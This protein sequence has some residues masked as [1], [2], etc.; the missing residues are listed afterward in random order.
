MR[1]DVSKNSFEKLQEW[2]EHNQTRTNRLLGL[3][4]RH[5]VNLSRWVNAFKKPLAH[6]EFLEET[7]SLWG[8]VSVILEEY[9]E[10][11]GDMAT[12]IAE[13]QGVLM[14]FKEELEKHE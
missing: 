2:S 1:K 4:D 11:F 13:L 8:E 12:D 7:T 14:A 6:P 5:A 3:V 10:C 9:K